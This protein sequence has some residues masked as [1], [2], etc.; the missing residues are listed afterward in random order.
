MSRE[1]IFEASLGYFLTPVKELLDDPT[2]TEIM[3]NGFDE[4]Y[5]E[6]R[7]KLE[8]TAARFPSEDALLCRRSSASG[9]HRPR[10]VDVL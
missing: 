8:H 4:V 6:R 7:G 9:W 1:A 5:I 2:V 10:P 3:V